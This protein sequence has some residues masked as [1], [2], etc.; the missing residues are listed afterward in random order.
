MAT[1]Q[2]TQSSQSR[3]RSMQRRGDE[4][5]ALKPFDDLLNYARDY[6]RDQPEMAALW[7]LGIGFVLGWKLKPW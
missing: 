7:C 4:D 5:A 3:E 1:Q 6:A 2:A